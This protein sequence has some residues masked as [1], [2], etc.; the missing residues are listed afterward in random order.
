MTHWLG[1][2]RHVVKTTF[3]TFLIIG[4]VATSHAQLNLSGGGLVLVEEGPIVAAGSAVPNN[5]ATGATAFSSSD[6]GPQLS[7][8]FHVAANLNDQI[9]GNSNSWISGDA[10]PFAPNAIAG[11]DFGAS[12]VTGIQSIAFGRDSSLTFTDRALGTYTLQYTQVANPSTDINLAAT[13]DASTGWADIGTL[14]YGASDGPGTNYNDV[15]ARHRYNFDPVDATG[16]RFIVPMNGLN[17][18]TAIEEIELYD[19]AGAFVPPPPPPPPFDINVEAGFGITWDGNDGAHFDAGAPPAGAIVPDNLALASNGATPF[20][21][22]D[23]GPE[24]G[25]AFHVAANLNDGFYGNSNSWI[26]ASADP[27]GAPGTAGINLGGEF[28]IESIAFGRD[29]GNGAIDESDPGT[30]CCGGVVDDRWEGTYTLQFTNAA[31]P[32]TAGEVDWVTIGTLGYTANEDMD[33]GGGFTGFLRHEFAVS[34]DNNPIAAT[35]IRIL[36][37]AI[38]LGG[39]TAIDEIEVYGQPVPEPTALVGMLLGLA[40]FCLRRRA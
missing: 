10:D 25:I 34:Q 1:F 23:L 40:A 8:G 21:S 35:G 36:V 28:L 30:D 29:N 5:L 27:D 11:I 14:D 3:A 20:S 6:L 12:L 19:V 24:L 17:G 9:Y 7:I 33:L 38:G 26:S 4:I 39:G 13:G 37:P 18:G 22:S 15:T 32:A 16:V 2:P 31:D